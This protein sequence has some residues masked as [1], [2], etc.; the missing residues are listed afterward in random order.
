MNAPLTSGQRLLLDNI[1]LDDKFTLERGRAFITGTQAFI[2]LASEG[3]A[4]VPWGHVLTI[5]R[6]VRMRR[7]GRKPG[8]AGRKSQVR[9]VGRPRHW[10][11]LGGRRTGQ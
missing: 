5:D 8:V 6:Q 11:G 7:P 10:R 4:E 3:L 1:S 9:R 2:R